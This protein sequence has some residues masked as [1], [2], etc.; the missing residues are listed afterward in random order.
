MFNQNTSAIL[1][2]LDSKK[3]VV[4]AVN[5]EE[6][7][8]SLINA[9]ALKIQDNALFK[10]VKKTADKYGYAIVGSSCYVIDNSSGFDLVLNLEKI[11]KI[12]YAPTIT[13]I[14]NSSKVEFSI[15]FNNN[16]IPKSFNVI[17]F[18]NFCDFCEGIQSFVAWLNK[19]DFSKLVHIPNTF[20]SRI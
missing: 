7:T 16:A 5:E 10:S 13:V 3:K 1:E 8:Q 19:Q 18:A 12:G 14:K 2:G 20:K 4:C 11:N 9:L 15:A 17:D 6:S